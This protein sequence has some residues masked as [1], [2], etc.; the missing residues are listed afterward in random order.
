[1]ILAEPLYQNLQTL[2][3]FLL[4]TTLV[5]IIV[6]VMIYSVIQISLESHYKLIGT[7]IWF[8]DWPYNFLVI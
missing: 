1:M 6:I 2:E 3:N 8:Q 7:H 5:E 4:V